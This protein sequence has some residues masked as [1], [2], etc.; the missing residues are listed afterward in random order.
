MKVEIL[1]KELYIY[2]EKANATYLELMFEDHDVINTSYL[3]RP[4]FVDE[5]PDIIFI[6]AISERYLTKIVEKLMPYKDR[7]KELIEDGVHLIIMNNAMD[8]FGKSLE[9]KEIDRTYQGRTLGLLDYS[10]IRDYEKR[11]SRLTIAK[12][13][14]IEII[15]QHMGFSQ[16]Y[17]SDESQSIYDIRTG[18]GFNREIKKGG[19]RYKNVFATELVGEL[20]MLNPKVSRLLL[21]DLGLPEDLPYE[22]Q[23]DELYSFTLDKMKKDAIIMAEYK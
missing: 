15:G 20:F 12:Y 18:Y 11:A 9:I 2:G 14:D 17:Y 22:A 5:R 16:Y 8:I 7:L 10:T 13:K 4:F 3:E 1:Y 6:D 21:K 19:F 23:V